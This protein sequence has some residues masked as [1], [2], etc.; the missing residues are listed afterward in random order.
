MRKACSK[1]GT[2]EPRFEIN[3]G[4]RVIFRKNIFT[5]E[6][7]KSLGLNE[8]QIKVVIC[9]KEKGEITNKEYREMTGL[10]D[11]GARIDINELIINGVLIS[12]G[13]G[14]NTYYVLK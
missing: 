14:R 3:H 7:L 5:E 2:P 6:H 1:V 9:V 4:F 11:E 12:K 8:K 13:R 10:S